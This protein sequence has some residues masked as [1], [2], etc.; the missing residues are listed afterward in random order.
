MYFYFLVAL[1]VSCSSFAA[2]DTCFSLNATFTVSPQICYPTYPISELYA[3]NNTGGDL[4]SSFFNSLA[5]SFDLLSL[6]CAEAFSSYYCA[7]FYPECADGTTESGC[8]ST[9]NNVVAACVNDTDKFTN[10]ELPLPTQ[11]DCDLLTATDCS[12]TPAINLTAFYT[13]CEAYNHSLSTLQSTYILCTPE[14]LIPV[15]NLSYPQGDAIFTALQQWTEAYEDVPPNWM[16][17]CFKAYANFYC[18]DVYPACPTGN[19]LPVLPV[20]RDVCTKVVELC[21]DTIAQYF[22]PKYGFT[23]PDDSFCDA[24]PNGDCF[25]PDSNDTSVAYFFGSDPPSN[26]TIPTPTPSPPI[27]YITGGVV[28]PPGG[29]A[30]GGGIGAAVLVGIL[31]FIGILMLIMKKQDSR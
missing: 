7:N 24:F 31:G 9:C 16:Y 30:K 27:I 1:L 6:P 8:A 17:P 13:D 23:I 18:A 20:C 5:T 29:P 21:N 4:I 26:E 14:Y 3:Q 15:G 22:N 28:Y 19:A 12:S 11:T 10:P 2:A 25:I